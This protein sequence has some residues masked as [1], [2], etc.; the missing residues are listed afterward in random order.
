MK[1]KQ[2]ENVEVVSYRLP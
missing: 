2:S 1:N